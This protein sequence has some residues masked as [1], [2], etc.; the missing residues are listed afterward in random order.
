MHGQIPGEFFI[1]TGNVYQYAD[2]S[3][4]NVGAQGAFRGL[5]HEAA[6]LDVF[7]NLADQGL[8][9][10][11]HAITADIRGHQGIDI[12]RGLVEQVVCHCVGES[13]ETSILG[14]EVGFTVDFEHDGLFAAISHCQGDFSF[15][16]HPA[17]FLVSL[18]QAG[19]AQ[20]CNCSFQVAVSF[21]QRLFAFHHACAGAFAQFFY[22]CGC[23]CHEIFLFLISVLMLIL[24]CRQPSWQ[25]SSWW[26]SFWQPFSWL[27][28]SWALLSLLAF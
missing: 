16:R 10:F 15:S 7:A 6:H 19:L 26:L 22:H 12:S 14:Y 27:L 5:T 23:Y 3:A 1:A 4:V 11:F 9:G 2:F 8:A 24:T 13:D 18:G 20:K 25:L 17:C 28:F 21:Y